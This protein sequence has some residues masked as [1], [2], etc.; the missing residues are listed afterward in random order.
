MQTYK[1]V[2]MSENLFDDAAL[3]AI[4]DS[5]ADD[6]LVASVEA[7]AG[8]SERLQ[9]MR[10]AVDV[11]AAAPLPATPE[12]RAASIAAAMAA[13]TPASPDVTS[14]AAAR[15]EKAEKQRRSLPRGVLAGVAAAVAFVVAIPIAL[16]LGGG[17]TADFAT[18]T[19]SDAAVEETADDVVD[20]AS[21]TTSAAAS[22]V[23]ESDA[24][25]DTADEMAMDDT[26]MEEEVVEESQDAEDPDS[27]G[28]DV[29]AGDAD[30]S[31]AEAIDETVV[32]DPIDVEN[33]ALADLP[34]FTTIRGAN[35]AIA[36]GEIVPFYSAAD[37]VVAG[38]REDCV[39]ESTAVTSPAPYALITLSPF[40]GADRLVVIEF[41]DNGATRAL[42]AE[43]CALLR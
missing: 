11:V 41:A 10:T 20:D 8:A 28:V 23:V 19:S 40:G 26:A 42:D 6:Q 17:E 36:D 3:S 22:A 31:A 34:T 18:E 38:V 39:A 32:A 1:V 13:A 29:T 4:I 9:A 37:V 14:L 7:N 12:R 30:D 33:F 24:M 21:D 27:A 35:Q 15:H 43:D 5:E 25:E 16:S 2:T